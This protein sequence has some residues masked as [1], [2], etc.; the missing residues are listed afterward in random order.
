MQDRQEVADSASALPL[1]P[2]GPEHIADL[3]SDLFALSQ[4]I[5]NEFKT[6]EAALAGRYYVCVLPFGKRQI[7]GTGQQKGQ[8]INITHWI[9]AAVKLQMQQFDA[10]SVQQRRGRTAVLRQKIRNFAA[11]KK[12]IYHRKFLWNLVDWVYSLI[13]LIS[14]MD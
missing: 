1:Q 7:P 13:E 12:T 4:I 3:I 8:H 6:A 11:R 9:A 14:L 10:E 5:F 2:F